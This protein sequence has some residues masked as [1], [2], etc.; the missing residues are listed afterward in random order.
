MPC[1]VSPSVTH[2][3]ATALF[4]FFGLKSVYSSTLG[5]AGGEDDLSEVEAELKET[6]TPKKGAKTKAG[7]K[8]GMGAGG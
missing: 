7:G 5:W 6:K 8:K 2:H 3:G 4:F 1:Q